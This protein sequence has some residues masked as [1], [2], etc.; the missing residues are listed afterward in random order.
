MLNYLYPLLEGE[1]SIALRTIGFDPHL[2]IL[3]TDQEYRRSFASDVVEPARPAVDRWLLD[4]IS[5][6]TFTAKDFTETH[7]GETRLMLLC[8]F[9]GRSVCCWAWI[10]PGA[11]MA[12]HSIS[13]G[14]MPA[15]A[16]ERG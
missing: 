2:G 1:T 7:E 5:K 13:N 14:R 15:L 8:H 9:A 12:T 16:A 6:R 3:H 11:G 10:P 4:T